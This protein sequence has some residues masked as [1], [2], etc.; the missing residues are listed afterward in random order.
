MS[1][2]GAGHQKQDGTGTRQS[3]SPLSGSY[4]RNDWDGGWAIYRTT[5]PPLSTFPAPAPLHNPSRIRGIFPVMEGTMHAPGMGNLALRPI[6][7]VIF[8]SASV[9][10]GDAEA[11]EY[12]QPPRRNGCVMLYPWVGV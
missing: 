2:R 9:A 1:C 11:D 5:D 6:F 12:T 10:G 3:G 7:R 8:F 4:A